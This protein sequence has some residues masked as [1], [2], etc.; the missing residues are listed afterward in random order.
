VRTLSVGGLKEIWEHVTY[1]MSSWGGDS[2][3]QALQWCTHSGVCAGRA[4][5]WSFLCFQNVILFS[6]HISCPELH[7]VPCLTHLTPRTDHL[8]PLSSFM[9]WNKFQVWKACGWWL[10]TSKKRPSSL[11]RSGADQ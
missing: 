8:K 3:C 6:D 10:I 5:G 9:Q 2:K 7:Q 11:G 4:R 1:T